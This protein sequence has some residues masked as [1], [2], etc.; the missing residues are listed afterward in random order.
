MKK[1]IIII[2]LLA[3]FFSG[4]AIGMFQKA[5]DQGI[6]RGRAE[7]LATVNDLLKQRGYTFW[8]RY[9]DS[10]YEYVIPQGSLKANVRGKNRITPTERRR[11]EDV[12]ADIRK[13]GQN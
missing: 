13:E 4:T 9:T 5:H 12:G 11:T 7:A 3:A 8:F 10:V 6:E 2:A 1:L